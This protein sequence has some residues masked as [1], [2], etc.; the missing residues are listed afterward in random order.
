[1]RRALSVLAELMRIHQ[2][3]GSPVALEPPAPLATELVRA[4]V[5]FEIP[6]ARWEA[7]SK[8]SQNRTPADKTLIEH[9]LRQRGA[10]WD[11]E[12]AD[13]MAREKR[14]GESG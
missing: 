8:L 10:R 12:V 2:P 14:S 9:G 13:A 5:A 11:R 1:M 4:I 3:E 6:V 7:K